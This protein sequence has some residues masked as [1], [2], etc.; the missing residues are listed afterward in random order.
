MWYPYWGLS[1]ASRVHTHYNYMLHKQY[2]WLVTFSF[3]MIKA[4]VFRVLLASM[5]DPPSRLRLV[6]P[7]L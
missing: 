1:A 3:A 2:L 5:V 4:L 6:D 7:T